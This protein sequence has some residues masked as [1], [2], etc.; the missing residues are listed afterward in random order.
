MI[1][2]AQILVVDDSSVVRAQIA[3]AVRAC[4]HEP[5]EAA[6]G[7]EALA[8]VA[9]SGAPALV[10]TDCNMP[11]VDGVELSRRLRDEVG[12]FDGT[13]VMIST[14]TGMD[15]RSRAKA[16]GVRYF[17]TKPV[18]PAKIEKLL[19]RCVAEAA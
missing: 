2:V 19:H 15:V 1:G 5:I 3:E 18:D 10:L 7:E 13:I 17:L 14:E 12:A 9:A 16:A 4:G 8:R 11:R 6:D